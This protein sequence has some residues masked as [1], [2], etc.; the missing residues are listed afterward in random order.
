MRYR[1]AKRLHPG[2]EVFVAPGMVVTVIGV[3]DVPPN[4]MSRLGAVL[5]SVVTADG[6]ARTLLHTEVK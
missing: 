4:F 1:E 2:D 6:T 5:V 3:D